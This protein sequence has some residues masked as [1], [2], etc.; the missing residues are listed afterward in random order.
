MVCLGGEQRSQC[1]PVGTFKS[2]SM[3]LVFTSPYGSMQV[4]FWTKKNFCIPSILCQGGQS[5][6]PMTLTPTQPHSTPLS[7]KS[8]LHS[9]GSWHGDVTKMQRPWGLGA[10]ILVTEWGDTEGG[11]C[12][13]RVLCLALMFT[14]TRLSGCFDGDGGKRQ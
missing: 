11:W 3:F 14:G 10:S 12:L 8:H 5:A 6:I 4:F 9:T 13:L 7:G 2:Q 1:Q